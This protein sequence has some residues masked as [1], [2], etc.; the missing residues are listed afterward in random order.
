MNTEP[1]MRINTLYLQSDA[2]F[3]WINHK[4]VLTS[5]PN[6][7]QWFGWKKP[8]GASHTATAHRSHCSHCMFGFVPL[9]FMFFFLHSFH[10][11]K[12]MY[13]VNMPF[14]IL[15]GWM[16]EIP[17][18]CAKSPVLTTLPLLHNSSLKQLLA[19]TWAWWW[20]WVV[21]R[22]PFFMLLYMGA[23]CFS[24]Y[25]KSQDIFYFLMGQYWW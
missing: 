12:K 20:N 4:Q 25:M 13:K 3:F 9:V 2:I 15:R 22:T 21:S 23:Q 1:A 5:K 14:C 19:G 7:P 11:E 10:P 16:C 17:K 6:E 18:L 24:L 8:A